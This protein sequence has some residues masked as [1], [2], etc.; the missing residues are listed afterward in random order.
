MSKLGSAPVIAWIRRRRP[1]DFAR[2]GQHEA[3]VQDVVDQLRSVES[4][5]RETLNLDEQPLRVAQHA[6]EPVPPDR[7]ALI[8]GLK[9]RGIG[10]FVHHLDDPGEPEDRLHPFRRGGHQLVEP[11]VDQPRQELIGKVSRGQEPGRQLRG[12]ISRQAAKLVQQL[13]DVGGELG[14]LGDDVAGN[15]PAGA[16]YGQ[17]EF[18]RGAEIRQVAERRAQIPHRLRNVRQRPT[19]LVDERNDL[20]VQAPERIGE[21]LEDLSEQPGRLLQRVRHISSPMAGRRKPSARLH[22]ERTPAAR[23]GPGCS[24]GRNASLSA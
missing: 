10:R 8:G 14:E 9:L 21:W 6:A 4:R 15:R 16:L 12:Q 1:V 3:E 22:Q 17:I 5:I 11:E 2:I 23:P 18:K 19:Q 20:G 24:S 7:A 13:H